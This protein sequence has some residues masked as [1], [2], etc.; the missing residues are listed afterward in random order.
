MVLSSPSLSGSSLPSNTPIPEQLRTEELRFIRIPPRS[1]GGRSNDPGWNTKAWYHWDSE[2][3]TF[4]L[5]E[6]NYNYGIYPAPGSHIVIVDIDDP[7]VLADLGLLEVLDGT[8][9]VL[10]GSSTPECQKCHYYFETPDILRGK[11]TLWHQDIHVGEVYAQDPEKAR[12]YVVGPGSVHPNGQRY[13]VLRD[14]PIAVRDLTPLLGKFRRTAGIS[15]EPRPKKDRDSRSLT[16]RLGLCIEQVCHPLNSRITGDQIVGGHPVHGSATG[17]NIHLNTRKNTWYCHRCGSGGDPAMWLAVESGAIRC[18]DARPGA[19]ADKGVMHRLTSWMRERGYPIP[20]PRKWERH[21][22][23]EPPSPDLDGQLCELPMTELGNASRLVA[24]FGQDIRYCHTFKAWFIWNGKRWERDETGNILSIA[25]RMVRKIIDESDHIDD[26]DRRTAL[27]K[28]AIKSQ[29]L[30]VIKAAITLAEDE[31]AARPTVFDSDPALFN[32]ENGTFNL[33]TMTFREHRKDDMLTKMAGTSYDPDAKCPLWEEHLRLVFGDAPD[34]VS[35]FQMMCGYSLLGS[36]PEQILF[37][38]HGSGKNGKSV[39]ITT[40]K[41]LA[42]D[43]AANVSPSTLMAS[44]YEDGSKPRS[45]IARLAGVRLA[46]SVEGEH[47]S[48]LGEALIK[49]LTGND[50]VTIRRPYEQEFEF[51]PVCKIWL[52]TN[53]LPSIRGTD[54]AIWRRIW[55]MPFNVII[56]EEK[57]VPDYALKFILELPGIL[58]WCLEGVR[59]YHEAGHLI[60]PKR[61]QHATEEYKSESDV[62]GPFLNDWCVLGEKETC[63]RVGLFNEYERWCD[64]NNEKKF[65]QK[66]FAKMLKEHGIVEG[67][68]LHGIRHWQKIRIKT[69]QERQKAE[70]ED[71]RA[72]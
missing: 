14:L 31:V 64:C 18:E 56:P 29:K 24:R 50:A 20:E 49:Q 16:D 71:N 33:L 45:D 51:T 47:T 42:G 30:S 13:R 63:T 52:A 59:R 62:L 43:Y 38:L 54:H 7:A 40:L 10:T 9:T 55:L 28:H 25:K 17:T 8:F 69:E 72:R 67:P 23:I 60:Q 61:V 2:N 19:L 68:I 26:P 3:L 11:T 1:K 21:P 57:R 70:I 5:V 48:K 58:N 34:F 37:I 66:T 46:T 39:T 65:T 35:D 6:E 36:N 41:N 44:K 32:L 22:H 15:S 27:F 53:H 4:H 12:G